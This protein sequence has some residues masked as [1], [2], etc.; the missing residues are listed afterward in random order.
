[1]KAHISRITLPQNRRIIAI[2]D[3]HGRLDYLTGLLDKLRFGK[4]DILF[5][6]GDFVEKGPQSLATLRYIMELCKE[7]TVHVS[8]GNCDW[9]YPIL[10]ADDWIKIM[11]LPQDITLF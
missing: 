7:F 8:C 1:M 9:W 3:I 11:V 6:V 5:I 2:S 10:N 4:E